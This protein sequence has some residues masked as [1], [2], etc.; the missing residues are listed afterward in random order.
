MT[1]ATITLE[2]GAVAHTKLDRG[3]PALVAGARAAMMADIVR[4]NF[5]VWNVVL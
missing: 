5:G 1:P 4:R 2:D 3:V